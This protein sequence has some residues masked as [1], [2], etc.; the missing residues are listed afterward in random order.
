GIAGAPPADFFGAD[1]FVSAFLASP[2]S[3]A[4]AAEH[5]RLA[6]TI[7]MNVLVFISYHLKTRDRTAVWP[8]SRRLVSLI[9]TAT[10]EHRRF[11]LPELPL[12]HPLLH[13][14]RPSGHGCG[15]LRGAQREAVSS[16]CVDVHLSRH[17]SRFEFKVEL[18]GRLDVGAIVVRAHEEGG[19]SIFRYRK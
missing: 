8:G 16:I 12:G 17:V 4:N 5:T 9:I 14:L 7:K 1:F 13:T 19:W 2:L 18:R 3:W 15:L 10:D 11:L 6:A